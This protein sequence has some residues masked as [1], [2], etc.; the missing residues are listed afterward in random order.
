[1]VLFKDAR[2]MTIHEA[3]VRP[4]MHA[5]VSLHETVSVSASL[6]VQV[7]RA[8]GQKE[9]VAGIDSA[10]G[11]PVKRAVRPAAASLFRAWTAQPVSAGLIVK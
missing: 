4:A 8:D 1:M 7:I 11:E 6:S 10:C 5:S 9:T 2:D 3:P